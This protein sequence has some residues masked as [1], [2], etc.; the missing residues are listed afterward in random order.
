MRFRPSRGLLRTPDTVPAWRGGPNRSDGI[1]PRRRD[2]T[3]RAEFKHM[4]D[5]LGVAAEDR[6]R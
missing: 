2:Y 1:G 6:Y 3:R 4:A 5:A